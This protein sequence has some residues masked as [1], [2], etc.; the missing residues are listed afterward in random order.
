MEVTV[1]HFY[2]RDMP[3][4]DVDGDTSLNTP[5]YKVLCDVPTKYYARKSVIVQWETQIDN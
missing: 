4:D 1:S 3:Q 2:Y 5:N